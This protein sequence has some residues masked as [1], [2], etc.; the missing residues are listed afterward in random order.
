MSVRLQNV[1]DFYPYG[2]NSISIIAY[3]FLRLHLANQ[4]PLC[5]RFLRLSLM[6][7]DTRS[8]KTRKCSETVSI[9]VIG[10][11]CAARSIIEDADGHF[12]RGNTRWK[13]QSF[14]RL[15]TNDSIDRHDH[16]SEAESCSQQASGLRKL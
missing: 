2:L 13:K 12:P 1:T 15:P 10:V 16:G 6:F 9:G 11:K 4:L 8:T 14:L 7:Y 3:I 5:D